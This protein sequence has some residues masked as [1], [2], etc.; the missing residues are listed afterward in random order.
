MDEVIIK[1]QNGDMHE[2]SGKTEGLLK[3]RKKNSPGL[4]SEI[5]KNRTN[6]LML[7]PFFILFCFFTVVPILSATGLSFTYFNMLEPPRFVGWT[8]YI[9]LFLDD[10][11]F[12]IAIKNTLIFAFITGPISYFACLFFA[13]LI[14]QLP[15][16]L[17][18]IMTFVFY[19][20]SISG[21]LFVIWMFIFSGDAYGM[22]NSLLMRIGIIYE[23]VQ[24]LTDARYNLSIVII[25]QIWLSLGASFLSFIAGFQGINREL[26]DAGAVDG[27]RNR[28]QE[29]VKIT[30]PSMGPQLVF[31]AVMQI[32]ASFSVGAIATQLTGFPSTDYSTHTVITHIQD[33][34]SLR[35]EMGYASAI[36]VVL[37]IFILFTNI[38]I[39]KIIDRYAGQE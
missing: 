3:I 20:P 14:N 19:I 15:K 10:D 38:L 18:T 30:L 26:Y 2:I 31:G 11:I 6:Y 25:V 5:R 34:G 7:A 13:W 17:K 27:I 37:F 12:L 29:L 22:V 1:E 21:N 35:F 24:W 39:R 9:R 16:M 4:F 23:P 28:F 8:N 33:Y 36:S 32:S